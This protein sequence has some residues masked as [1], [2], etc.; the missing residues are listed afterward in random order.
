VLVYFVK[1]KEAYFLHLLAFRVVAIHLIAKISFTAIIL[2]GGTTILYQ[3][4]LIIETSRPHSGRHTIFSKTP[5]EQW[6]SRHRDLWLT[7]HDTHMGQTSIPS[8]GY[9]TKI[10]ASE[11]PQTHALDRTTTGIGL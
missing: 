6:P 1:Y 11:P 2:Y 10:A 5:L 3:G 4:L 7:T 9:E 8:A